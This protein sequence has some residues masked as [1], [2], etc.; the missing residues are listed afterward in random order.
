MRYHQLTSGERYM[1]SALRRQGLSQAAIARQLGRHRSTI[2]RELRRNA[3]RWDRCYRP[4]IAIERTSGRRSRSRRNRRFTRR[5]LQR[6]DRL[7]RQQWSPQQIAGYLARHGR[8]AI[9]HETIYRYVWRDRRLG[10]TLYQHLRGACKQRRKRYGAYDSRGRLAGKRHIS[11]RPVIV[12]RRA[13]V[14]DWEIDTVM[15]TGATDC[16]VSL[17]ERKTGYLLLG[18]LAARTQVELTAQTLRLARPHPGAFH[19]ITSDNGTEFHD[20]KRLEQVLG[21]TFY[22]ATPHHAWER[23]SNENANGL[24]R[25]YVPKGAS[26][27][28]LSAQDCAA[29]AMALNTRPRKRLNYQTPQEC[30]DAR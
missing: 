12:D 11:E 27:A 16:L 6:I 22:F 29:I 8:L 4:S 24:I 25:Q 5:D 9:S 2:C 1:L 26:M 19:T 20:Y 13:R 7:L 23:G 30:F 3:S 18:K 28:R 15:G 17:V 14:G 10:G 21:A